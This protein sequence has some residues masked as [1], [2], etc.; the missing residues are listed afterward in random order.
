MYFEW[1]IAYQ[2]VNDIC[3]KEKDGLVWMLLSINF[4]CRPFTRMTSTKNEIGP[5]SYKIYTLIDSNQFACLQWPTP[6]EC[7]F[8][9][10]MTILTT[11]TEYY[12]SDGSC[13]LT[14]YSLCLDD[15][16]WWTLLLQIMLT[17]IQV[18]WKRRW[19]CQ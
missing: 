10:T 1:T 15:Y 19:N 14:C 7:K 5:C 3:I 18:V 2:W 12:I 17:R 6:C 11:S 16:V 8:S 4:L 13:L 9:F